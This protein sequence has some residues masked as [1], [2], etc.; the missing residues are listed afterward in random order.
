[1]RV[2]RLFA[3]GR[4]DPKTGRW[5][6]DDDK[7]PSELRM[8]RSE[9][10]QLKELEERLKSWVRWWVKQKM[11]GHKGRLRKPESRAKQGHGAK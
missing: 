1:M 5:I 11:K 7:P 8:L 4:I 6:R 3:H 10:E 9:V 2:A